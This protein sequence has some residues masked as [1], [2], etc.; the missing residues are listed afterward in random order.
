M[1]CDDIMY[2]IHFNVLFIQTIQFMI[3]LSNW[4]LCVC[5]NVYYSGIAM[6]SLIRAANFKRKGLI[7]FNIDQFKISFQDVLNINMNVDAIE[8]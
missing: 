6:V 8:N 3:M 7:D 2:S 4:Y 5:E 1:R